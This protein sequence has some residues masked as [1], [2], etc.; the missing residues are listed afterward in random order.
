M[1]DQ[2]GEEWGQKG[3]C[4]TLYARPTPRLPS[5]SLSSTL[6][7]PAVRKHVL[8]CPPSRSLSSAYIPC[9]LL[10]IPVICSR[11]VSFALCSL[12]SVHVPHHLS[13]FPVIC[14]R[15]L[16]SAPCSLSSAHA[17]PVVIPHVLCCP[18]S[19]PCHPHP[20][21]CR[22]PRPPLRS[23]LS[24]PTFIISNFFV[25]LITSSKLCY[26]KQTKNSRK[27]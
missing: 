22:P 8:Y 2:N 26:C 16:P 5:R 24:T 15:S 14:P 18:P 11:S 7:F 17:F 21:P 13:Q 6:T 23:P 1:S 19:N 4:P 27:V 3:G 25:F 9:H 20:V 10:A 12:S